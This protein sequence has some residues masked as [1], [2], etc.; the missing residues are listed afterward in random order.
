MKHRPDL[1]YQRTDRRAALALVGLAAVCTAL[2]VWLGG[3]GGGG[4]P[5]VVT[6]TVYASVPGGGPGGHADM[7]VGPVEERRTELFAFDPNTADSTALLRLG[8]RPWQVRAIYRYRARGGVT[9]C[10]PPRSWPTVPWGATRCA[11]RSS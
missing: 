1:F 9:S 3:S 6:D 7:Y 11:T 2:V 5:A 8:L 4:A 10:L